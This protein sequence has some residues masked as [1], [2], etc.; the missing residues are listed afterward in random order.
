[1]KEVTLTKDELSKAMELGRNQANDLLESAYNG[2]HKQITFA[3]NTLYSTALTLISS[4]RFNEVMTMEEGVYNP[5]LALSLANE[6]KDEVYD[7]MSEINKGIETG[8]TDFR[9]IEEVGVE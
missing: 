9:P 4:I 1:M 7:V 6:T 3:L 2:D 8:E 5:S